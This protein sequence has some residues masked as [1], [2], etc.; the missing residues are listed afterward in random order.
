MPYC[1]GVH[2]GGGGD[3]AP[4]GR[5]GGGTGRLFRGFADVPTRLAE[6]MDKR[7]PAFAAE[8]RKATLKDLISR[9]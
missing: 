6:Y 9:P 8:L 7:L 3:S 1:R 5:L 4:T 2:R